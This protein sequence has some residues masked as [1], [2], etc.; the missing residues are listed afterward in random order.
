MVGSALYEL[1]G[2]SLPFF[3][4]GSIVTVISVV[5]LF[6]V[7]NINQDDDLPETNDSA[8]EKNNGKDFHE[9]NTK[10]KLSLLAAVKVNFY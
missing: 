2:F 10:K 4:I 9:K 8:K 7:P 3:V 5:L 1:G 6:I